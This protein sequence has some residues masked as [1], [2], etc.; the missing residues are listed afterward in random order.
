MA[1]GAHRAPDDRWDAPIAG[2]SVVAPALW[3]Q[4]RLLDPA[5]RFMQA[6]FAWRA[7]DVLP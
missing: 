6:Q 2:E 1:S 7:R 4:L 3:R 5:S